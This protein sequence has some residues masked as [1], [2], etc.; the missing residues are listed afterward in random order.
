MDSGLIQLDQGSGGRAMHELI[1]AI[2]VSAFNNPFLA[3]RNDSAVFEIRGSRLAFTTDSF[4]VDPIFFPG[5]SIGSL[6]VHG[7]VNDLAMMG[8]QPRYL[9]VGLIIEE[10]FSRE[11]LKTILLDMRRAAD[12]TG[13]TIVTGDT[14]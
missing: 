9:S 6:A 7:T 1:D 2:F 3:E 12:E 13:V 10:G 14:K 4:V 11:E 5:G 8:A